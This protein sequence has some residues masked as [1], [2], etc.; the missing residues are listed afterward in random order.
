MKVDDLEHFNEGEIVDM[1][2]ERGNDDFDYP[3]VATQEDFDSF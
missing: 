1:M 2:I 3:N